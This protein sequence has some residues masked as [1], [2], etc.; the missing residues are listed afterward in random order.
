MRAVT[1]LVKHSNYCNDDD[2][3]HSVLKHA[4]YAHYLS[5]NSG[6]NNEVT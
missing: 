2:Q 3:D 4:R 5:D 6:L 1:E